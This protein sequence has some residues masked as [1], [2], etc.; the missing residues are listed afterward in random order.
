MEITNKICSKCKIDKNILEFYYNKK[1][2]IYYSYCNDCKKKYNN[3]YYKNNLESELERH[4]KYYHNHK[5]QASN[6]YYNKKINRPESIEKAREKHRLWV[7]NNKDKIKE[8]Y[9]APE[10]KLRAKNSYLKRKNKKVK[11]ERVVLPED[12]LKRR[13]KER[14]KKYYQSE[15]GKYKRNKYIKNKKENNISFKLRINVSCAIAGA[16]KRKGASKQGKSILNYLSYSF[17]DLKNHLESLFEPWMNWSN[18]GLYNATSWDDDNSVTWT[19]Q[20]DHIIPQSDLLYLSLGDE[21]F[22]KVWAL[23]NLRPLSAKQN[24]LD[25]CTKIRHEENK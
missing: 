20:I 18:W 7:V 21:N 11:I 2:N 19:W 8:K 10:A 25:G 3:D 15:I 16:L 22:K 12:E 24:C 14:Q 1:R 4:R 9:S 5:K 17:E 6:Y 13:K 23:A